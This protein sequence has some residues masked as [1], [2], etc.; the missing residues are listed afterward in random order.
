MKHH[1]NVIWNSA[2]GNAANGPPA[3]RPQVVPIPESVLDSG[4]YTVFSYNPRCFIIQKVIRDLNAIFPV[5]LK[6]IWKKIENTK[7][8]F[9]FF[10]MLQIFIQRKKKYKN[11][12]I[13]GKGD[14]KKCFPRRHTIFTMTS[15]IEKGR[16]DFSICFCIYIF[17]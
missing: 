13:M 8:I 7:K 1:K 17:T 6:S 2:Y 14:N 15:L 5:H 4:T 10:H 16:T 9:M 12:K 11:W 3:T